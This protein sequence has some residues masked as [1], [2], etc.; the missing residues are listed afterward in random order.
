MP[1]QIDVP[2]ELEAAARKVAERRRIPVQQLFLQGAIA[3]LP[4]DACPE[5]IRNLFAKW[6]EEWAANLAVTP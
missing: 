2:P 3:Q 5:V 4:G 6:R 1:I